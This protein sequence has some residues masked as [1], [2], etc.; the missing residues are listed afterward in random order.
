MRVAA[1]TFKT[2]G[3][4]AE[5]RGAPVRMQRV[6]VL[7]AGWYGVKCKP[8]EVGEE[9]SLPLDEAAGLR[10]FGRVVFV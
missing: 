4:N 6:R 8:V 10:H 5:I 3:S 2:V 1:G 9:F 7:V